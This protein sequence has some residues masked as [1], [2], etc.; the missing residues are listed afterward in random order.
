MYGFI[1]NKN[2]ETLKQK[3]L[4][5]ILMQTEEHFGLCC[6]TGAYDWI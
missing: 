2:K 5:A 1:N 6:I 3:I 4:L